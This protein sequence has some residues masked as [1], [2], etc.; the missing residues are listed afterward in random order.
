MKRV[1]LFAIAS[2]ILMT[3]GF[4]SCKEAGDKPVPVI[5]ITTHPENANVTEGSISESSLSLAASV[6]ESATLSYQWFSAASTNNSG[7]T[8]LGADARSANFTIPATLT[9]AGSPYYYFCEVSAT[10]G[11]E[12][13]RSNAA[14]ITVAATEIKVTGITITPAGVVSIAVGETATLMAT[15]APAD[16]TNPNVTWSSL[17]TD[18]AAVDAETGVITGM[19]AG[20][21][22]IRATAVDG[23]GVTADRSVKVISVFEFEHGNGSE[24]NPYII[25]TPAQLDAIRYNLSAHYKLGNDI[26]LTSYLAKGGAGYAKWGAAGW[27]PIGNDNDENIFTG[28]LDGADYKITGIWITRDQFYSYVGLFCIIEGA[29]VKNLGVEIAS[30]GIKGYMMVGG[31]AGTVRDFSSIINCYTIGDV[32][33]IGWV[34]GVAG[35]VLRNCSISNCYATGTIG[36]DDANSSIGGV[37]GHLDDSSISSCYATGNV[38]GISQVGGVAGGAGGGNL[39]NCYSTGTISCPRNVGGV[40]GGISGTSITNCYAAGPVSGSGDVGSYKSPPSYTGGVVGYVGGGSITN[41]IALNPSVKI[42]SGIHVGRV[43]GRDEVALT[44]NWA[45]SAM[46]DGD[47]PPFP[48]GSGSDHING[49]DCETIPLADWWRDSAGWSADIWIFTDGQ[50]PKLK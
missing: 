16:A 4:I 39:T 22:I 23:S 30:A 7:G 44:N 37:V 9:V 27:L 1:S 34:G 33:G 6:T 10:G 41:C 24:D 40:A 12:S 21:V 28:S 14:M 5:T 2:L 42:T 38:S 25:S 13:I 45:H 31:V 50:L 29:T 18:C 11:A 46:S 26:D 48:S 20:E 32:S 47:G 15:V 49:A 8:S 3:V 19:G 36:G 17:N 35:Y 43:A